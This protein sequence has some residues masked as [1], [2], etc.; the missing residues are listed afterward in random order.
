MH[1][2]GGRTIAEAKQR[3]SLAEAMQWQAYIN[4]NGTLDLGLRLE[5][6]FAQI[7]AMINQAMGGKAKI[8]DFMP[9]YSEDEIEI[10]LD[11]AMEHW[12]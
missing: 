8:T 3:M 10:D 4:K 1:G 11:T 7:A 6:H 12:Q 2:I 5:Y 9:H